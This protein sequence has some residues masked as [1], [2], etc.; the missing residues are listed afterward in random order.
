MEG[1]QLKWSL[2]TFSGILVVVN[3]NSVQWMTQ[4]CCDLREKS[5]TLV[6]NSQRQNLHIWSSDIQILECEGKHQKPSTLLWSP[7]ALEAVGQYVCCLAFHLPHSTIC[8]GK[9]TLRKARICTYNAREMRSRWPFLLRS[10]EGRDNRN[11]FWKLQ[12]Y[13]LGPRA[14]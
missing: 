12:A 14:S 10:W 2:K 3:I 4:N 9:F 1:V 11:Y 8:F 7:A 6:E 5:G 13:Y